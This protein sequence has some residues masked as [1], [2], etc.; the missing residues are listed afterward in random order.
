LINHQQLRLMLAE[1]NGGIAVIQRLAGKRFAAPA[2]DGVSSR[3]EDRFEDF[4]GLGLA[5]P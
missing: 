5:T 1:S 3:L 4:F 2:A